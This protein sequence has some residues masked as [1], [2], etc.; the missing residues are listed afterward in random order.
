M[1]GTSGNIHSRSSKLILDGFVHYFF[2]VRLY[3]Y[4]C[5]VF[6]TD[7]NEYEIYVFLPMNFS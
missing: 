4:A 7:V 5:S 2:F 1:L 6:Q 3:M